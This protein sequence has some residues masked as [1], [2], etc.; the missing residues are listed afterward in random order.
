M[1]MSANPFESI[2]RGAI[3]AALLTL[4]CAA[5]PLAAQ[6]VYRS[7]DAEGHVTYSDR[8]TSKGAPKTTLR[9]EQPDPAEVARLAHEQQLLDADEATRARQQALEDRNRATQQRKQQ[10]ACERA[11]NNYYQIKDAARLYQPDAD[12]N[13]VYFS[14]EDADAKR[15]QARRTMIVACGS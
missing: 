14:D 7:V 2:I 3:T 10:Q 6:D 8:G 11:R 12:G 9:V 4:A 1:R 13:R 5:T 15:E